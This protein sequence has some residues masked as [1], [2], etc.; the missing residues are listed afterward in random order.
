MASRTRLW[1]VLPFTKRVVSPVARLFAGWM[2]GFGLLTYA[3][4]TTGRIY[5]LPIN[6]FQR[7][8]RYIFALTYG[9]DSQWVRN[10]MAAG[11]CEIRIRGRNIRLVEP[12]LIVDPEVVLVPQPARFFLKRV[13]RVTELLRMRAA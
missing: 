6:V 11:G 13:V 12:E 4:R 9:S 8:D 10:V 3:G 7:G 2:P 1:R 5:H